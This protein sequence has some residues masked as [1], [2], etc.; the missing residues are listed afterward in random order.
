MSAYLGLVIK[1][2]CLSLDCFGP[3][4]WP[5]ERGAHPPQAG[6]AHTPYTHIFV[7]AR[8]SAPPLASPKYSPAKN[9][10]LCSVGQPKISSLCFMRLSA[11]LIAPALPFSAVY[12]DG[13]YLLGN[14]YGNHGD[15]ACRVLSSFEVTAVT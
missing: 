15:A 11:Q 12:S 7:Y 13:F 9:I 5:G 6:R 3:D 4:R 2:W 8:N 14:P 10:R 1:R